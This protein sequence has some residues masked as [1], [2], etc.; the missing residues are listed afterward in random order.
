[1]RLLDNKE[2]QLPKNFCLDQ[3]SDNKINGFV[4]NQLIAKN[5]FSIFD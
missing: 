4:D 3:A 1:M 2:F 5:H